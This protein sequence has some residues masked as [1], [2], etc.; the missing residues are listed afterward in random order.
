VELSHIK[1]EVNAHVLNQ[2]DHFFLNDQPMFEQ[3]LPTPETIASSILALSSE[4]FA[5]EPYHP[6]AVHLI[7]HP[8]SEATAYQSG[9]IERRY[10]TELI[11]PKFYTHGITTAPTMEVVVKGNPDPEFGTIIP[12][13]PTWDILA[14]LRKW[15]EQATDTELGL[16]FPGNPVS[17]LARTIFERLKMALPIDRIRITIRQQA[18]E[19]H[20]DGRLVIEVF[21]EYVA[22]HRLHTEHLTSE[23]NKKCF[24]KCNRPHGHNF[25]TYAAFEV[26]I[27]ANPSF[28]K[29]EAILNTILSPWQ[30]H[31]LD[32]ETEFINLPASTETMISKLWTKLY[33]AEPRLYRVR[34]LETPNNRFS[35][36]R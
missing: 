23:E 3:R 9:L 18:V 22:T 2:F 28:S 20:A 17:G 34:L 33:E 35:V 24:G 14:G 13:M 12:D 32:L 31:A 1:N 16:D 11:N 21:S 27:E 19:Y 15:V 29:Y 6:V 5:N 30:Y 10:K 25:L 26:P 4:L 36:R 8:N 7:E